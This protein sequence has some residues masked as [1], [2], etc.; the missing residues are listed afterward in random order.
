[1]AESGVE[2][3]CLEGVKVV[4]FTQF[5]A[6]PSCTESLAWLGAEV[7]KIENPRDRRPRPPAAPGAA[8]QGPLVFPPVQRQQEIADGEPEIAARA[9]P[10][11]IDA[12]WASLIIAR[13]PCPFTQ[14]R[15]TRSP[16]GNLPGASLPVAFKVSMPPESSK[17]KRPPT[18]IDRAAVAVKAPATFRGQIPNRG[19]SWQVPAKCS[20]GDETME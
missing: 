13:P 17:R 19:C 1:M 6:G 3:D 14:S 8:R 15:T 20:A 4:D 18:A 9:L 7:V 11:Q 2:L 5:E 16:T 10:S 12:P